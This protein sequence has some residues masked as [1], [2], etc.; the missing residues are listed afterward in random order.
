MAA[1]GLDPRLNAFR[2]DLASETLKG[3]VEAARYVAGEILQV[4]APGGLRLSHDL[5][6]NL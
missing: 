2:P 6:L 5:L 1:A 4:E 3:R